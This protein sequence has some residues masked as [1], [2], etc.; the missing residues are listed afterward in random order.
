MSILNKLYPRPRGFQLTGGRSSLGT[1]FAVTARDEEMKRWADGINMER[2]LSAALN[3]IAGASIGQTSSK[4]AAVTVTKVELACVSGIHPQGYSMT[5]EGG[6]LRIEASARI[7]LHYAV[8]TA[9]QLLER[10]GLEWEHFHIED[11]PDFPVRGF[12]LD[13]GRN[14]IPKMDTLFGLIDTL[15]GLKINHL[16]LYMEGYPF[17]YSAYA[18]LFPDATPITAK[19]YEELDA[20]AASR[21]IDLVPNQNCLG[22]MGDWLAKPELREL[23]EHPDGMSPPIPLP[24]KLP[25]TTLNPTDGRS[26][27]LVKTMLDELLPLF[28]SAYAN[29]NM[30]EPFGL[31]TGSSKARAEQIGVGKLYMEYADK[32][33]GLVQKHGKKTLMWGDII[34][35]HP[36]T[37]PLLPADVTVLDWNYDNYRSFEASARR[38]QES[39][40][41]Y[42]VCPGTSTWA[43]ITGRTDNML[44][45]I[46]DAARCG[47]AFG[48]G[49][50]I[51][52]DWGD[53]GHWQTLNASYPGIVYGAGASWQAERNIEEIEGA[54]QYISDVILKDSTGSIGK[55]LFELGR[56]YRLENSSLDNMT[57]TSYLLNRGL[58]TQEKL[59]TETN[60]MMEL[61]KEIGA[62]GGPFLLDYRYAEM[63]NWLSSRKQQ[64]EQVQLN[65]P[66]A[67]TV[68]EELKLS[69]ALIEQGVGLH[70]CV[71][72]IELPDDAAEQAL[73]VQ[74]KEQLEQTIHEFERLWLLRNRAGGLAR[75]TK[76]L[77]KLLGQYE[78]KLKAFAEASQME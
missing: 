64:L 29:I 73:V 8:L 71:Y 76:A 62:R 63:L 52:T 14:K 65:L 39:G 42:Y 50:F 33:I 30:D 22:H 1:A 6:L 37:L 77:Y 32:V 78:E 3:R 43:A 74:L 69:V 31:G 57:Y 26:L 59:E 13:I 38:L 4:D 5:W 7:G 17:S 19:E 49:G 27:E 47:A 41:P 61:Y 16:Q 9:E 72:R 20:Y 68:V 44:D 35:K 21:F 66:D 34:A 45:N 75:S 40:V 48:A 23:A 70:R 28:S 54:E 46:A 36:E 67:N 56:Y 55:L 18:G 24:F 58:S 11:E 51:I 53:S 2:R 60:A 12:M 25:P 10:S 15:S